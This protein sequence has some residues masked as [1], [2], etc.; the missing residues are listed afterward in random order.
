MMLDEIARI[1]VFDARE[2][3]ANALAGL[4]S[5]IA[6]KATVQ[7]IETPHALRQIATPDLLVFGA[8]RQA[9]DVFESLRSIREGRPDLPVIKIAR[10]DDL[11]GIPDWFQAGISGFVAPSP[12][13]AELRLAADAALSGGVYLSR[14]LFRALLGAFR[15]GRID[16]AALALT[17]REKEILGFVV[18]NMSNKDI[19]RK[20]DLSVRTVETHRLHIRKK[21]GAKNWRDLA[22][23]AEA[24]GLLGEYRFPRDLA[25]RRAAPGF[26]EDE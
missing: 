3:V 15:A 1:V 9:P 10:R 23:V 25:E 26:H 21:T 11:A 17:T 13:R 4:L 16:T 12:L 14:S 18:V 19:A 7:T 24:L 5:E 2:D 22:E 8:S 6:V 20:L